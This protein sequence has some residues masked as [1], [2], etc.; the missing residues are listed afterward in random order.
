MKQHVS[1]SLALPL[2]LISLRSTPESISDL[3]SFSSS[4]SMNLSLGVKSAFMKMPGWDISLRLLESIDD[5]LEDLVILTRMGLERSGWYFR[6][7]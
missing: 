1:V 7:R 5:T 6:S 2:I 4:D 3:R